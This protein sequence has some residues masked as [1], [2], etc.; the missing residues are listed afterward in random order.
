MPAVFPLF[1]ITSE[2]FLICYILTLFYYLYV[3]KYDDLLGKELCEAVILPVFYVPPP[4]VAARLVCLHHAVRSEQLC[5]AHAPG[6]GRQTLVLLAYSM[7]TSCIG[8]R[9]E[10]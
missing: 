10:P 3:R 2:G 7:R 6:T 1:I 4:R 8:Q 5:S 9:F